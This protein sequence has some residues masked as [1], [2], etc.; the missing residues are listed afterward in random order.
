MMRNLLTSL[1]LGF[2]SSDYSPPTQSR[3]TEKQATNWHAIIVILHL[4]RADDGHYLLGSLAQVDFPT[5]APPAAASPEQ[6][7][8]GNCRRLHV[9][10]SRRW[11]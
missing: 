10:G 8:S 11:V 6:E 4:R 5:S 1:A 3:Q 7:R 2:F 9:G